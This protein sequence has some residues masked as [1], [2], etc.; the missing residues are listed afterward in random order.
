MSFLGVATNKSSFNI[1]I[2][3]ELYDVETKDTKDGINIS[4]MSDNVGKKQQNKEKY[5]CNI[6]EKDKNLQRIM[7]SIKARKI[8]NDLLE[9]TNLLTKTNSE[10]VKTKYCNNYC[11]NCFIF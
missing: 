3:E 6:N 10:F 11:E 1:K 5:I 8:K 7:K 2:K 9:N 4:F